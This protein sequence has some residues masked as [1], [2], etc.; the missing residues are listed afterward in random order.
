MFESAVKN[1]VRIGIIGIGFGQQVHVPAF[2][3][4]PNTKIVAICASSNER[5]QQVANALDIENHFGDWQ[6][7]VQSKEVD[8]LSVAVPPYLQDQIVLEALRAGKPVFCEKPLSLSVAH[9]KLMTETAAKAHLPNMLDFEFPEIP[10]WQRAK[11]ILNSGR[12]GTLHYVSVF[13][14]IETYANRMGL[15]SWKTSDAQ[16]GGVLNAFVSHCFYN[17]EWLLGPIQKLSATLSK[18]G[19]DKQDGYTAAL[20]HLILES[21]VAVA[22]NVCSKA[23][24]GTGHQLEFY[25]DNA[26]LILSNNSKDYITGFSLLVGDRNSSELTADVR[27]EDW[28]ASDIDGRIRAVSPLVNRFINWTINNLP[29]TPTFA[30]GLRVQ[31]LIQAARDSM[32]SEQWIDC[33]REI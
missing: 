5:A 4:N 2:R 3:A 32:Q 21:G 9:A 10:Q 12:L 29:A 27:A 22:I 15:R 31:Q 6:Q 23:L 18:S 1:P 20:L 33:A 7:L 30:D 16:G 8:A 25:G 26:T 11:E 17:I 28:H 19:T 13:W 14:H 24:L